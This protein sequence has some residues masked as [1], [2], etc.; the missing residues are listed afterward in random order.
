MAHDYTYQSEWPD[1]NDFANDTKMMTS[2]EVFAA[3]SGIV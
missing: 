1:Y 3:Y 2:E